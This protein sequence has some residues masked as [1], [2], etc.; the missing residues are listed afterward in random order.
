VGQEN[1][2]RW[3]TRDEGPGLS[4]VGRE[5]VHSYRETWG[6]FD[7]GDHAV[8][9]VGLEDLAAEDAV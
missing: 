5:G 2:Y 8:L 4:R 9:V 1:F 6:A 3:V 7:L